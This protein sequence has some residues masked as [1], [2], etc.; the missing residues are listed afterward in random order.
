[1]AD[2]ASDLRL[3][4]DDEQRQRRYAAKIAH[5]DVVGKR[6]RTRA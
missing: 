1:V 2:H 6:A 4:V 3:V 5:P